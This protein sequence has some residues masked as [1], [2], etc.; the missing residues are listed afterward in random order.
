[1]KIKRAL[2][3]CLLDEPKGQLLRQFCYG[4]FLWLFQ[5]QTALSARIRFY[6]AMDGADRSDRLFCQENHG[7]ALPGKPMKSLNQDK[8]GN[9]FKIT[10]NAPLCTWAA[11][12]GFIHPQQ[13]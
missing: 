8:N 11:E 3:E 1:M 6:G 2:Q 9:I 13:K 10:K 4:E 7:A 5:E 12:G